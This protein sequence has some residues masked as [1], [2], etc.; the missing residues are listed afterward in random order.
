MTTRRSVPSLWALLLVAAACLA[1][2]VGAAA[3]TGFVPAGD[4][5]AAPTGDLTN[6]PAVASAPDGTAFV[7]WT[8]PGSPAR[9]LVAVHAPGGT[10]VT[11]DLGAAT[12]TAGGIGVGAAADGSATVVAIDSTGKR[13]LS[14]TRPPGGVFGA[15]VQLNGG[16]F[17][18]SAPAVAVN[19]AGNAVA[20]WS[21][22][23]AGSTWQA[24]GSYREGNVWQAAAN[25]LLAKTSPIGLP[26]SVAI[27]DAGRS[28]VAF[29]VLDAGVFRAQVSIRPAAGAFPATPATLN[30]DAVL[31]LGPQAAITPS[32]A[33]A[34]AYVLGASP[35]SRIN[36][37]I[38]PAG[39]TTFNPAQVLS[40]VFSTQPVVAAGPGEQL[41]AAWTRDPMTAGARVEYALGS[42]NGS[43]VARTLVS[44]LN[45]R[46]IYPRLSVDAAGNRLLAWTNLSSFLVQG[47]Y[48]PAGLPDFGPAQTVIASLGS[49]DFTKANVAPDAQGNSVVAWSKPDGKGNAIAQAGGYD[50]APPALSGLA[51]PGATSA[52]IAAP[53]SVTASDVWSA[54]TVQWAFGDG[55][56]AA[57]ASVT[58]AY[59][60]TGSFTATATATDLVGNTAAAGGEVRVADLDADG[61][62]FPAGRDCNDSSG[63]ANPGARDIPGNGI[64]ENCNGSDAAF[65]VLNVG[66]E[67]T[68]TRRLGSPITRIST[69]RLEGVK[70]GDVVRLRCSGRGCRKSVNRKRT[71]KGIKRGRYALTGAVA[72]L[73][74]SAGAK[75]AVTVER[76]EYTTRIFT[77]EMRRGKN[78][79]KTTRC[80]TPGAKKTRAC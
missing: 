61:D 6:V 79:R 76:D 58:H 22:N 52:T 10:W 28:V 60:S 21:E 34:V 17:A 38:A 66:A 31:A 15:P 42:V 5:D 75:L 71:L 64:D 70:R 1:A 35:D 30:T 11:Q 69:L 47:A 72:G 14:Y 3:A 57:G 18:A 37:R 29:N 33:I 53:F 67:L 62:G 8:K 65:R 24:F 49:S 32:G 26:V 36:W 73:Q 25:L 78:P 55:A 2:P 23:T 39:S 51:V 77:Y 50:V 13:V 68:W 7:A 41:H 54:P 44:P 12:S 74:L 9:T 63:A 80:Q 46:S 27:N 45:E 19:A 4:L 43:A 56:T 48:R 40:T 20:G 16:G 59:G